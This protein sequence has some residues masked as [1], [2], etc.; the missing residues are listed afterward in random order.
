MRFGLVVD[1]RNW[2]NAICPHQE[3]RIHCTVLVRLGGAGIYVLLTCTTE[4]LA[5]TSPISATRLESVEHWS[6]Q[7]WQKSGVPDLFID[8]SV[9]RLPA[10]LLALSSSHLISLILTLR[11]TEINCVVSLLL[12]YVVLVAGSST[13]RIPIHQIATTD[14]L[15]TLSRT[16]VPGESP[17]YYCADP[18]DDLF[19]IRRLDFI[20]TNPRM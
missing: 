15:T 13:R 5:I 17:A 12:L 14:S 19:K 16:K 1:R 6:L 10:V 11:T 9:V 2:N 18:T 20:P 7:F 4:F 8:I 3:A